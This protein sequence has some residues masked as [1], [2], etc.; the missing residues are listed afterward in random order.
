MP[1]EAE[2]QRGGVGFAGVKFSARYW[3]PHRRWLSF[4][5][6]ACTMYLPEPDD[7]QSDTRE[8]LSGLA[9]ALPPAF[10]LWGVVA[11]VVTVLQ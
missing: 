8:V 6:R 7:E 4:A 9:A 1:L 2:P 5:T 10:L 11:L 3:P